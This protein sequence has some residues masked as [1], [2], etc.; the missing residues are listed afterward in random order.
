MIGDRQGRRH[1][2]EPGRSPNSK[3]RHEKS[4]RHDQATIPSPTRDLRAERRGR[5]P[6]PGTAHPPVTG[7]RSRS[8][9]TGH[10]DHLTP[11]GSTEWPSEPCGRRLRNTGRLPGGGTPRFCIAAASATIRCRPAKR[12]RPNI[13]DRLVLACKSPTS[14]ALTLATAPTSGYC[15]G[16]RRRGSASLAPRCASSTTRSR[17]RTRTADPD[18][19]PIPEY[20]RRP[21]QSRAERRQPSAQALPRTR[22]GLHPT[23]SGLHPTRSGDPLRI[24]VPP[25]GALG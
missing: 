3:S 19:I 8:G 4:R 25:R 18:R 6:A 11:P 20:D 10:A 7:D 16:H 22:A 9:E 14:K 1:R 2:Q 21:P 24:K 5:W 12:L 17:P 15:H 13:A 23:R